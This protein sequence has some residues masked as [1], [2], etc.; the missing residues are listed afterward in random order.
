MRR[1]SDLQIAAR[2]LA[3]E[4]QIT[5]R[6]AYRRLADDRPLGRPGAHR[7]KARGD[8][9]DIVRRYDARKIKTLAE[10]LKESGLKR[11][12]FQRRAVE[13]GRDASATKTP[14]ADSA[15]G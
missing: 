13:I 4:A 15:K 11:R 9:E 3:S 6:S 5:L 14:C 12:T 10:A 7:I 1:P 2:Q 8:L